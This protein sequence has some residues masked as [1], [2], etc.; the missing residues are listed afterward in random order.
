MRA[1]LQP[2]RQ[3]L[4]GLQRNHHRRIPTNNVARIRSKSIE[5]RVL[6]E[7]LY[8]LCEETDNTYISIIRNYVLS[9]FSQRKYNFYH[10]NTLLDAF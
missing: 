2:R 10:Q 7:K 9:V 3:I 4:I 8:F 1:S 6:V 5:K